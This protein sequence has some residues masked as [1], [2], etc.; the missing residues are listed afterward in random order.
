MLKHSL[1]ASVCV[2]SDRTMAIQHLEFVAGQRVFSD[3][4]MMHWSICTSLQ[5]RLKILPVAAWKK[6]HC[7]DSVRETRQRDVLDFVMCF[8]SV[9]LT[10]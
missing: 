2:F 1:Q 7:G 6:T 9:V 8:W 3:C 5:A 10:L 4:T